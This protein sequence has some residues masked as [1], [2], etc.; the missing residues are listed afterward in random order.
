[1]PIDI[2]KVSLKDKDLAAEIMHRRLIDSQEFHSCLN[3]ANWAPR[4][5]SR[6]SEVCLL[7]K[8]TPPAEVILF[9][10]AS[11]EPDIPF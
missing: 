6:A 4:G 8:A 1:M 5:D 9:S 7:Y 3:C 2:T 10:C 11:W